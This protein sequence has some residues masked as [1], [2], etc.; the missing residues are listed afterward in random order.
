MDLGIAGRWAVIAGSSRGLGRACAESL[1]RE[2]VNVV[3]NGRSEVDVAA[4]ASYIRSTFKV[5]ALEAVGDV[6][7]EEGRAAI[8]SVCGEPD[9]LVTNDGGPPPSAFI[10]NTP[11]MWHAAIEGNFLSALYLMQAVLP[12]MREK[13]F[14]R[15]INITSAMV[16]SPNPFMTLSIGA[17]AGLTGAA[18]AVSKE[19]AVDNVTINNILPERVNTDRQKQMAEMAVKF[20]GITMDE[21]YA[22]MAETIAAKRL[23]LPSEVGDAC[24]YLCSVQASFISGQNL[25]LDGGSYSGLI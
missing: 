13:K 15:I 6:S 23:G 22:E 1:A 20:K 19:V 14:G 4:T 9:I 21:A 2:G 10:D 25:H 24:A 18:K 7:T 12:K 8:L 16:T 11:E 5:Q 3:I 17:R